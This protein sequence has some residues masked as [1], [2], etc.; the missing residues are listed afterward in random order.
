MERFINILIIDTNELYQKELKKILNGNGNNILFASKLSSALNILRSKEVGILILNIDSPLA[1]EENILERLTTASLSEN[2]YKFVI[3]TD[4][5]KGATYVNGSVNGAVDYIKIPFQPLLI[6]S[7]IDVFR[8]MY[9]KD[10]R[11]RLLLQ[12]IF[13]ETVLRD[14]D[15]FGKFSPKRIDNGVVLF[16]DFVGFS[17]KAKTSSPLKLLKKLEHYFTKFDEITERF[18]VEKI[19]TIGD[20]YMAL[21]GV[22]ENA[23][24]PEVR[25]CLAAIEMRDF[26]INE[27]ELAQAL[28]RDFWEVRI[29]IHSGPLVAGIIGRKKFSFDVW[30]DTVNIAAR[31]EQSSIPG[32]ILITERVYELTKEYFNVDFYESI[33]IKTRGGKENMFILNRIKKSCSLYNDGKTPDI[34]L[35]NRCDLSVI[36]FNKMRTHIYNKLKSL[37]PDDLSYHDLSHTI[38]VEKAALRYARL[39]GLSDYDRMLLRTAVCYHDAGFLVT[40]N[41]NEEFG[42]KLAENHLPEFGYTDTEI[43]VI[44]KIIAATKKGVQPRTLL[45]KIMCDADHDYLGRADYYNVAEKL[46]EELTHRQ[47]NMSELEWLDFQ[48]EFLEFGHRYY[49]DTARNIREGGKQLRIEE[50]KEKRKE[51]LVAVTPVN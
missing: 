10:F 46:R 1:S 31:A 41:N 27:K 44:S 20:S 23:P 28:G 37:L 6:K 49:T 36:D 21:A 2:L 34:A 9:I 22:T 40:Y 30:G 3:T 43:R 11:I 35:M 32:K 24:E 48:L 42:I 33:D 39:E 8:S 18:K 14:L 51:L 45:E 25:A 4:S 47:K 5:A 29:G 19:K 16:T 38:N 7:K 17:K 15:A 26:M 12:N 13:P 50:L